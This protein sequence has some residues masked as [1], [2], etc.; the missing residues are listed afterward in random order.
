MRASDAEL[1]LARW[2]GDALHVCPHN[3]AAESIFFVSTIAK[4]IEAGVI[5]ILFSWML[6]LFTVNVSQCFCIMIVFDR[7]GAC[8]GAVGR[9]YCR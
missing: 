4:F 6:Y 2:I 7:Y 8:N 3:Y 9:W 1:Y 5:R